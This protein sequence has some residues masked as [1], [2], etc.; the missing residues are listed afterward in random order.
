MLSVNASRCLGNLD[1]EEEAEG[2]NFEACQLSWMREGKEGSV[3]HIC[4]KQKGLAGLGPGGWVVSR[5]GQ[6]SDLTLG[7]WWISTEGKSNAYSML[8][9]P[10]S[11]LS[12]MVD[13]QTELLF[14]H[15]KQGLWKSRSMSLHLSKQFL[16][17]VIRVQLIGSPPSFSSLEIISLKSPKSNHGRDILTAR[18]CR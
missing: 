1:K 2:I 8:A 3:S 12:L 15:M 4:S 10:L 7:R 13:C 18:F 16:K 9:T 6:W 17:A 14:V 5:I 11:N